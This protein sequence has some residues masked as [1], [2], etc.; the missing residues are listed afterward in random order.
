MTP[1]ANVV[2][3]RRFATLIAI[4]VALCLSSASASKFKVLHAF[5]GGSDGAYPQGGLAF[6]KAGNLYGV[7]GQGGTGT[8]CTYSSGC[9]VAYELVHGTQWSE[10]VL[11][12]FSTDNGNSYFGFQITP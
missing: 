7:T 5:A 8:G 2:C 3:F 6:D 1:R 10:R 9:G 4:F 11:Y 12:N